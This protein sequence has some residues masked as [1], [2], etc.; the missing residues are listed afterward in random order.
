MDLR[1]F[2]DEHIRSGAEITIATTAVNRHDAS[3]FGI[4]KIDDKNH[5]KEFMEKPKPDMNIEAWHLVLEV[6]VPFRATGRA[7]R[8]PVARGHLNSAEGTRDSYSG[9]GPGKRSLR[10]DFAMGF[11]PFAGSEPRDRPRG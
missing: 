2:M 10:P 5:V 1:A 6:A 8:M 11:P 4:M 9:C 7:S 3:G